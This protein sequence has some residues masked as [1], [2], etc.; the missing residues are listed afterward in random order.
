[1]RRSVL[2]WYVMEC[3]CCCCFFFFFF[4]HLMPRCRTHTHTQTHTHTHS[5]TLTHTHTQIPARPIQTDVTTPRTDRVYD[6]FV[7]EKPTA[8]GARKESGN[9]RREV[10]GT[11]PRRRLD[12]PKVR[13]LL[14]RATA[15]VWNVP[16]AD[17]VSFPQSQA[18]PGL[19]VN[20]VHRWNIVGFLPS[21]LGQHLVLA[22]QAE[23]DTEQGC[24]QHVSFQ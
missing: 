7:G 22:Q 12:H 16:S 20:P 11:A 18:V 24:D 15:A 8:H 23:A 14:T 6:G 2:P 19:H 17:I 9:L 13:C 3:F 10:T 21:T 4:G 5:Y 1:M